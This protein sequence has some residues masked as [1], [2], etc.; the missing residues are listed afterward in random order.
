MGNG[1]YLAGRLDG[2]SFALRSSCCLC[3]IPPVLVAGSDIQQSR[4]LL[5]GPRSLR[6]I[7]PCPL[8][9]PHK[10]VEDEQKRANEDHPLEGRERQDHEGHEGG[11]AGVSHGFQRPDMIAASPIS[12]SAHAGPR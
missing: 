9:K 12:P 11:S 6:L 5:G 2:G 3:G 4:I 10:Q 7:G 8:H 1:Y